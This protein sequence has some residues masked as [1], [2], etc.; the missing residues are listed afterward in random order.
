MPSVAYL[1]KSSQSRGSNLVNHGRPVTAPQPPLRHHTWALRPKHQLYCCGTQ[2]LKACWVLGHV[3]RRSA[4]QATKGWVGAKTTSAWE[5]VTHETVKKADGD[6]G[7]CGASVTKGARPCFVS[8]VFSTL[9]LAKS[10]IVAQ[11]TISQQSLIDTVSMNEAWVL[12]TIYC[13][14]MPEW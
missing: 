13:M 6:S 8:S 3:Y 5:S 7:W 12:L 11:N 1:S 10:M 9:L 4:Q 14:F 2:S